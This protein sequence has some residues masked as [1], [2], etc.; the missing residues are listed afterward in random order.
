MCGGFISIKSYIFPYSSPGWHPP[1]FPTS[2]L[3]FHDVGPVTFPAVCSVVL[4]ATS[5]SECVAQAHKVLL[6]SAHEAPLQARTRGCPLLCVCAILRYVSK[7]TSPF[8]Q[9]MS[10]SQLPHSWRH[11]NESPL[12]VPPQPPMDSFTALRFLTISHDLAVC[13]LVW[14][15]FLMLYYKFQDDRACVTLSNTLLYPAPSMVLVL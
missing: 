12:L 8:L 6:S 10:A 1:W 2:F 5:Y 4:R 11:K 13:W 9:E 15:L 14:C 3:I 7:Q